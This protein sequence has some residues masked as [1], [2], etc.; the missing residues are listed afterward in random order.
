MRQASINSHFKSFSQFGYYLLTL[1]FF[2]LIQLFITVTAQAFAG[3]YNEVSNPSNE[4]ILTYEGDGNYTGVLFEDINIYSI[5]ASEEDTDSGDF[6]FKGII[7][8]SR[9][10]GNDVDFVAS[11]NDGLLN[12]VS[13]ASG[14]EMIYARPGADIPE[15][16]IV[17]VPNTLV[18]SENSSNALKSYSVK[19]GGLTGEVVQPEEQY[20]GGT[21]LQIPNVGIA[22]QVPSAG[23]AIHTSPEQTIVIGHTSTLGNVSVH[24]LSAGDFKS[25]VA[26]HLQ[27]SDGQRLTAVSNVVET[28]DMFRAAFELEVNGRTSYLEVTG[29]KGPSGNMVLLKAK[30][31]L[32][33]AEDISLVVDMLLESLVFSEVDTSSLQI[34]VNNQRLTTSD[35]IID[36]CSNNEFRLELT[37]EAEVGL[38]KPASSIFSSGIVLNS[39]KGKFYYVPLESDFDSLENSTVLETSPYCQ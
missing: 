28:E 34:E 8:K 17:G 4:L 20:W 33:E 21:Q 1:S 23:T 31:R 35:G 30:S 26:S 24:A 3:T 16:I 2:S 39:I 22:L 12:L 13:E 5:Q 27:T 36:A 9:A 38:W 29:Q 25:F 32:P 19:I 18:V 37:E 6:V 10:G 14:L 15:N 7:L 11:L